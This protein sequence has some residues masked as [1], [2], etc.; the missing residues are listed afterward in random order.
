M[1]KVL[2][3]M[4]KPKRCLLCKFCK[5]QPNYR[6]R[7]LDY[8]CILL[9][10]FLDIRA[11]DNDIFANCP[12]IKVPDKMSTWE[13]DVIEAESATLGEHEGWNKCVDYILGKTEVSE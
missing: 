13:M 4:D 1:E 5:P 11:I 10:E 2:F 6:A 8:I 9:D 7:H 12:L 3:V